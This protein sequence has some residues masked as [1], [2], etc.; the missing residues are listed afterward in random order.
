MAVKPR[1]VGFLAKCGLK[2]PSSRI[3]IDNLSPYLGCMRKAYKENFSSAH[4]LCFRQ[5]TVGVVLIVVVAT[6]PIHV[7]DTKVLYV[8]NFRKILGK[9]A[10]TSVPLFFLMLRTKAR[11]LE[12]RTL[13]DI[14]L[15]KSYMEDRALRHRA[16]VGGWGVLGKLSFA[17]RE[18]F[19]ARGRSPRARPSVPTQPTPCTHTHKWKR[20]KK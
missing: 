2:I 17:G 16:A 3:W 8:Y 15:H 5:T 12:P 13:K 19:C 6:P 1:H 14:R 9:N 7:F 18:R 4:L 10:P 11:P 20:G